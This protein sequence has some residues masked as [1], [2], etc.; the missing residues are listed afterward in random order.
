MLAMIGTQI[1]PEHAHQIMILPPSIQ[2]SKYVF[3]PVVTTK[4]LKLLM[5]GT[6]SAHLLEN[7]CWLPTLHRDDISLNH[8]YSLLSTV[9]EPDRRAHTGNVFDRACYYEDGRWREL[10]DLRKKQK[11]LS[12]KTIIDYFLPKIKEPPAPLAD[13]TQGALEMDSTPDAPE[14]R[15]EERNI[16][17]GMMDAHQNSQFKHEAIDAEMYAFIAERYNLVTP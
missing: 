12:E 16:L 6:K 11:A 4:P 17:M 13:D 3:V 9:L 5:R 1:P 2:W 7:R 8:A 10:N 15:Q 14:A